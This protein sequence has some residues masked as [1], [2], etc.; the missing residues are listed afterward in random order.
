M[1]R[2]NTTPLMS[3]WACETGTGDIVPLPRTLPTPV[4]VGRAIPAAPVPEGRIV[5]V[6]LFLIGV[7]W[8]LFRPPRC[9]R[10]KVEAVKPPSSSSREAEAAGMLK[11][12]LA[13]HASRDSDCW[14][15]QCQRLG[16][17]SPIFFGG[18][19]RGSSNL[20]QG[21]TRILGYRS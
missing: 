8:F 2:L 15:D 17:H 4:P 18:L 20:L 10:L 16:F 6:P 14:N 13:A 21:H 12:A 19:P 9:L 7:V 1:A 11:P 3:D 5:A